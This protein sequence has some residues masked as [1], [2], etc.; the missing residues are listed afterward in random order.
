MGLNEIQQAQQSRQSAQE[1]RESSRARDL[2]YFQKQMQKVETTKQQTVTQLLD[3]NV[4]DRSTSIISNAVASFSK[5][6]LGKM[7]DDNGK[8][9]VR[10][11]QFNA[12]DYMSESDDSKG[13]SVSI[14]RRNNVSALNKEMELRRG[15]KEHANKI[16]YQLD[17]ETREMMRNYT[18]LYGQIVSSRSGAAAQ[19]M[20][21]LERKLKNDKGFNNTQLMELKLS[22]KQSLRTEVLGQIK[23]AFLKKTVSMEMVVE[24]GTAE[25][26]LSD[27]LGLLE[28]N[29]ELGGVEFGG[30]NNGLQGTADRA[31]AEVASEVR[32]A[33]KDMLDQKMTE[34]LVS[35]DV[36]PKEARKELQGLLDL[37]NKVGFNA[38]EYMKTWYKSKEDNGLFVFQRPDTGVNIQTNLQQDKGRDSE[39][40]LEEV[41]EETEDYLINRLRA[42][43]LRSALKNDWRTSMDTSLKIIKTKNK[44]IKLGIFSHDINDKVREE[45][46]LIAGMKIMEMLKEVFMERATLYRL[47]GPAYQLI[48][49]KLI[50]L[51]RNAKKLGMEL[52]EYEFNLLRDRANEAVFEVSK[53]ELK[54]TKVALAVKDTP[55]L[56]DKKKKLIQ[57]MERLKAESN[58]KEELGLPE[59]DLAQDRVKVATA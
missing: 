48:D 33:L 56:R 16:Q 51:M 30:F 41:S 14:T 12:Q 4:Q 58:I 42:L 6:T 18:Q 21:K 50:G 3:K 25:R 17:S 55:L 37:G 2:Q 36:D 13:D 27:L 23:D 28:G 29:A 32:M 1:A 35:S 49:A 5:S 20:D 39:A 53:R 8:T 57:L 54:L 43:Y 44:M 34:R 22:V 52:T 15:D 45:S 11:K 26:G 7:F 31:A 10:D 47:S 59:N 19:E 38:T 9:K 24:L 46:R 40:G